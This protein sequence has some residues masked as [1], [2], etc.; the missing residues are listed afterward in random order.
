MSAS[1]MSARKLPAWSTSS[2]YWAGLALARQFRVEPLRIRCQN[3]INRREQDFTREREPAR[4]QAVAARLADPS[5]LGRDR[6][7]QCSRQPE[8]ELRA[9]AWRA[10]HSDIAAHDVRELAADRQPQAGP[11]LP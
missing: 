8:R 1:A 4:P 7:I 10:I 6:L 2:E 5:F 3:L 9:D 11:V